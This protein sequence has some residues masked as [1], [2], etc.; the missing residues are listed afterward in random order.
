V[1]PK[2]PQNSFGI[3]LTKTPGFPRDLLIPALLQDTCDR[4]YPSLHRRIAEKQSELERLER[5]LAHIPNDA[6]QLGRWT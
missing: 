1:F 5:Q 2:R 4:T 3:G 6:P